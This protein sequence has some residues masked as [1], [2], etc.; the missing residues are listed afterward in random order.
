[1]RSR[2]WAKTFVLLVIPVNCDY[3][4]LQTF[5]LLV[6]YVVFDYCSI[7]TICFTCYSCYFGFPGTFLSTYLLTVIKQSLGK[8]LQFD[9]FSIKTLCFT[10]YSCLFVVLKPN[11]LFHLLFL[12]FL[13]VLKPKPFV[14]LVIP[15]ICC[16]PEPSCPRPLH[17]HAPKKS[18]RN[19]S[20]SS[21]SL[22][23]E[24]IDIS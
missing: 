1:M 15:V 22:S 21:A 20:C 3:L 16:F 19:F 7:K 9:C 18:V 12:S 14:L 23:P 8:S 6:I 24:K 13:I 2:A 5:V 11:P 17:R 4:S 10:C